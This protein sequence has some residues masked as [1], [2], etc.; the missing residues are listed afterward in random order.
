MLPVMCVGVSPVSLAWLAPRHTDQFHLRHSHYFRFSC[1]GENGRQLIKAAKS[2]QGWDHP[3]LYSLVHTSCCIMGWKC[4]LAKYERRPD[5]YGHNK[6]IFH[7]SQS[8]FWRGCV[9]Y[10]SMLDISYTCQ[11]VK[12]RSCK[13]Y[14]P[15]TLIE[16]IMKLNRF[17]TGT[18]CTHRGWR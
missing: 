6:P 3:G 12:I 1:G 4:L 16:N 2:G 5:G 18:E 13:N 7:L 8:L 14:L 11:P 9:G 17:C 10:I 15:S